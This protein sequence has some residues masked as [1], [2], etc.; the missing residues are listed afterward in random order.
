MSSLPAPWT[1]F[2]EINTGLVSFWEVGGQASGQLPSED[3]LCAESAGSDP[4]PLPASVNL[5]LAAPE[6]QAQGPVKGQHF[7]VGSFTEM[8]RN[9]EPETRGALS[10]LYVH[11]E[12]RSVA[13]KESSTQGNR[14]LGLAVPTREPVLPLHDKSRKRHLLL[15][16]ERPTV[17]GSPTEPQLQGLNV[18]TENT[19]L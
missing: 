11:R 5:P 2:A 10:L 16:G 7:C 12:I 3:K 1:V 13:M 9:P 15:R 8:E 17:L 4:P 18:G 14:V 6:I 19:G